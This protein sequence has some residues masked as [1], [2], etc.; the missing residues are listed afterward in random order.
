MCG[1]A[2]IVD[3]SADPETRKTRIAAMLRHL[4]PRGPDDEGEYHDSFMSLGHRRLAILD[5]RAQARQPMCSADGC[6]WITFNGEI[7]NFM[8]LRSDLQDLGYSFRTNSDTEVLLA[9]FQAWG[10]RAFS[11]LEGMFACGI[12]EPNDRRLT[13]VRDRFGKKPLYLTCT[14]RTLVFASTLT[15]LRCG[16]GRRP[17]LSEQGLVE[18]AACGYP[19]FERTVFDGIRKVLPG[20]VLT[21]R[22]KDDRLEQSAWNFFDLPALFEPERAQELCAD[23]FGGLLEA[24]V[25]KRLVSDRPVGLFL[26]GGLDSTT[27]SAL[28]KEHYRAGELH[29]F[30]CAFE[31]K[32]FSEHV[33][34]QRSAR[35]IGLK[36]HVEFLRCP[37]FSAIEQH[38]A[39][40]GEPLGDSSCLPM[41]LLCR[42]AKQ[43]VDVVL[44]GDG[45]DEVLGGYITY[46][47]TR[48][49]QMRPFRSAPMRR[50]FCLLADIL[51]LISP[52]TQHKVG[53]AYKLRA[54]SEGARF[55]WPASHFAWRALCPIADRNVLAG[56]GLA[57]AVNRFSPEL[58]LA[59]FPMPAAQH[60]VLR[61][62]QYLDFATWLPSDIL[63]KLDFTSMAF[64]LELRAPLL[65]HKLV[66][67][68]LALP[69]YSV[70]RWGRGKLPLRLMA[71]RLLPGVI[72]RRPKQGFNAPVGRWIAGAWH[73]Q[74]K[75]LFE[76][77]DSI[78]DGLLNSG[79]LLLLLERHRN[80]TRDYGY[81]LWAIAVIL[82]WL[83]N[84]WRADG[85]IQRS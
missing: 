35:H 10:G 74:V 61:C 77:A 36:L 19:L 25:K 79:G 13:L 15:A 37:D 41:W 33:A 38:V 82:I 8:S 73:A 21:I 4:A 27:I 22:L 81:L 40:L 57:G 60:D 14:S 3:L 64:G 18:Y 6:L 67:H 84:H 71:D 55:P 53:L 29:A 24:A 44:T 65:D 48:L 16:L 5:L 50:S 43:H 70:R 20:Q 26:S 63:A 72:S 62:S 52:S 49:A 76:Q 12:Y 66:S 59:D 69:S 23:E 80:H 28:A 39:T 78:S 56:P 9:A 85:V 54:F 68:C 45:G 58:L 11:R 47:A 1:I 7:Y 34:A 2:G 75:A 30:C 46:G 42:K 31:E 83:K 17:R 51:D 32:S